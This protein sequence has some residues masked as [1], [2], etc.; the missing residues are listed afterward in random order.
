MKVVLRVILTVLLVILG[1]EVGIKLTPGLASWTGAVP[2]SS[3]LVPHP[4]FLGPRSPVSPAAQPDWGG[5]RLSFPVG[6]ATAIIDSVT[7][8]SAEDPPKTQAWSGQAGG[9]V[10]RQKSGT[11]YAL[12]LALPTPGQPGRCGLF[13]LPS[14]DHFKRELLPAA[15]DAEAPAPDIPL[16]PQSSCRMQ[17][18]RG[19]A[20]FVGFYLTPDSVEA[21][22][23]FYVR[24]LSKLGWQRITTGDGRRE[25][26]RTGPRSPVSGH[27]V[28]ETFAK[29]NEDRTVVVQL[30]KQDS[31]T[32]RIGLVAMMS[33][34]SPD[35]SE[36]K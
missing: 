5:G 18:G 32:T 29:R 26:G 8:A 2:H 15:K 10:L 24:T 27:S 25:T 20:C 14:S 9:V 30:R 22:R 31:V 12:T 33:G 36:R 4:S 19:T 34:G 6:S 11:D 7:T 16:Y 3:F 13:Q 23:S 21:V 35:R 1:L 17:V 28:L